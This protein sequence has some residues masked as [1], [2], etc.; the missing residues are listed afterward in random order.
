MVCALVSVCLCVC[1]AGCA[2]A[3]AC[4]CFG[5][6]RPRQP[7]MK[8]LA[9]GQPYPDSKLYN[10]NMYCRVTRTSRD[11]EDDEEDDDGTEHQ[12]TSTST[13]IPTPNSSS[14]S[15]MMTT[16]TTTGAV[17]VASIREDVLR[18]ASSV[19]ELALAR[20]A[21]VND[22][23]TVAQLHT[24]H[25]PTYTQPQ[26]CPPPSHTHARTPDAPKLLS[27]SISH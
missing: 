9:L 4:A 24:R 3:C 15:T 10:H 22:G 18:L 7:T 11:N 17:T 27:N 1:D 13:S 21:S 19:R 12:Q 6:L 2:C 14:T 25:S 26:P 8:E 20:P 23:T 5:L 16:P